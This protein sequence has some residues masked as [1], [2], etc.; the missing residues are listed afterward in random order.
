MATYAVEALRQ[1]V[2]R[3]LSRPELFAFSAQEDA[4]RPF[5]S[6]LRLCDEPAV[7]QLAVSSVSQIVASHPRALGSGYRMA[8]EAARRAVADDSPAVAAAGVDALSAVASALYG[9]EAGAASRQSE[10]AAGAVGAGGVPPAADFLADLLAAALAAVGNAEQPEVGLRAVGVLEVAAHGFAARS[11]A[12]V[13]AAGAAGAEAAAAGAEQGWLLLL[14]ALSRA[15]AGGAPATVLDAANGALHGCLRAHS[16][17]WGLQAWRFFLHTTLPC[18]FMISPEGEAAAEAAQPSRRSTE[19]A[20]PPPSPPGRSHTGLRLLDRL[21][22]GHLPDRR[23]SLGAGSAPSSPYSGGPAGRGERNANGAAAAAPGRHASVTQAGVAA[24]ILQRADAYLPLLC[25]QLPGLPEGLQGE[26]VGALA[27]ATL[28]W[29]SQPAEHPAMA[30]LQAFTRLVLMLAPAATPREWDVL[31][32]RLGA[33][34]ATHQ[35]A[36]LAAAARLPRGAA[37]CQPRDA[38]PA[39]PGGRASGS[40]TAG[41]GAGAAGGS[42]DAVAAARRLRTQC[43]MLVL[44]QRCLDHVHAQCG[45]AMPWPSQLALVD[46]LKRTVDAARAFNTAPAQPAAAAGGEAAGEDA[47]ASPAPAPRAT[48]DNLG[49]LPPAVGSPT[50]ASPGPSSL[51]TSPSARSSG[52]VLSPQSGVTPRW[53]GSS[54]SGSRRGELGGVRAIPTDPMPALV[55]SSPNVSEQLPPALMRLEM[56]GGMLLMQCLL[57]LLAGKAAASAAGGALAPGAAG[58][59]APD[60]RALQDVRERLGAYCREVINVAAAGERAASGSE[61]DGEPGALRAAGATG[62]PALPA[63]PAAVRSPLVVRCLEVDLSLS[64]AGAASA[65]LEALLPHVNALMGCPQPMVRHALH[66]FMASPEIAALVAARGAAAAAALA[67]DGA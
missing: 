27:A 40:W 8:L 29:F 16:G 32:G 5:V 64:L 42:E 14:A 39:S 53:R 45:A 44:L 46:I 66:H 56:E 31:L 24:A 26:A 36:T 22:S 47:P 25:R 13:A 35:E 15:L 21:L 49:E 17:Q 67:A 1:L 2:G 34:A 55:L 50:V 18:L 37:D 6:V 9:P 54:H 7:R 4:L 20:H 60:A 63:W 3:Q 43:R 38:E 61:Q 48:R 41:D 11:A 62:A 30:G 59:S 65:P 33:V 23:R 57:R 52:G 10:A 19:E 51:P 58:S 12:A 28:H